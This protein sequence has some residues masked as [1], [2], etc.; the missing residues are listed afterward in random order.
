[1]RNITYGAAINEALDVCL[2]RDKRV[3]IVGEGVPDPRGIFGTTYG[4]VDKHDKN[5]VFDMPVAEN[6]MTGICIGAALDGMR[7]VMVH[8]RIDFTLL[9]F[10]QIVNNAAKWFYMFGGQKSVPIVIRMIIGRGWGQ[11]SQHSQ[12]LQALYAHIPGLKVVMPSTPM[13][14]KGML[15]SAVFDNNPVIYIDHR[16]LH[17][18]CGPVAGGYFTTSLE[19]GKIQRKGK[20]LTLVATSFMS[21]EARRAGEILERE[22]IEIEIIDG[23]S[24][25]PIDFK[26]II[27]S[28]GKTGKLLVADTGYGHF[29]FASEVI[30]QVCQKTYRSLKTAPRRIV[31]PDIPTPTAWTLAE[32]YYPTHLDIV[33][34]VLEMMKYPKKNIPAILEKIIGDKK[35]RSD[36][37]DATFKGPF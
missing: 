1:M 8:Q 30:S 20:D 37:P 13:D 22:G 15:I 18:V 5:R 36:V 11:G 3:L 31:L 24:I 4:L 35:V 28:V 7:P 14:A 19:G 33:K 17:N 34:T 32:K 21:L 12:P 9:S 10:D 29:G 27:K 26:T 6:G 23:R 16:W 25:K 2:S